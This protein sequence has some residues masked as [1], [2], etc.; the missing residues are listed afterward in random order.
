MNFVEDELE[1]V[2]AKRLFLEN[3]EKTKLLKE[4]KLNDKIYR[5][6]NAYANHQLTNNDI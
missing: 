1:E 3:V 5:G 6:A 2:K 4:G